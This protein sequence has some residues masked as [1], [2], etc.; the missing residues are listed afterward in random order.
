MLPKKLI[1]VGGGA[2]GFFCAIQA[3]LHSPALQVIILEKTT[4]L[5][6]KVKISGGGRCNVTHNASHSSAMSSQYPRGNALMKKLFRE[7]FVNDTI[8]FFAA[9]GVEIVS[10]SDGRMFPKSNSSESII[11][12]FLS[13]AARL[14]IHVE[15]KTEIV[16]A[17]KRGD[18]FLISTK[19]GEQLQ[20]HFLVVSCGGFHKMSH[21]E[22]ITKLGHRIAPPIPSLFTFNTTDKSITSLM[23][24]SMN[25]VK[26]HINGSNFSQEGPLLITHWGFSGPAILKLS[27]FAA[28]YLAEKNWGF[29]L[30]IHWLPSFS[31]QDLRDFFTEKRNQKGFSKVG[32]KTELGLPQR[33][34]EYLLKKSDI[35][36][37]EKR[38]AEV[39]AKSQNKLITCLTNDTYPIKGKTTY[40]E[41]FV[42]AGG[43]ELDEIHAETLESKLVSNL[44]FTGEVMNV[45]GITGGFNFQ[46]AWTSAF[47]VAKAIG[48]RT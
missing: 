14:Q 30:A 25:E 6:S 5:L 10:E 23:G 39:P 24:V 31:E 18:H 20:S 26:V 43:I 37:L 8:D 41:E 34:W 15:L 28:I 21:Y 4:K 40:K 38:W 17:E 36:D 47:V 7:F 1:I 12:C 22:W 13:E 9:R 44:F 11:Q 46:H 45:D 33:L 3:K 19:T 27:A 42:T 32:S 35:L 48:Q 29:S 16:A 2:S